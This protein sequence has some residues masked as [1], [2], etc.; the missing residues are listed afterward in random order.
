MN[1][2]MNSIFRL[3]LLYS[4]R[5]SSPF[6]S[7]QNSGTRRTR[8]IQTKMTSQ[9]TTLFSAKRFLSPDFISESY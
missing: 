3:C 2:N 8:R 7:F 1:I 6:S 5:T 4:R 9:S